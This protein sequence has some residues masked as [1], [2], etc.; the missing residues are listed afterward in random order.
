[1]LTLNILR[2]PVD[3]SW[4][5]LRIAEEAPPPSWKKVFQDAIPELRDISIL[6][7]EQEEAYGEYYPLKKDIFAAFEYTK[8]EDVKIVIF[9]QD[10]YHQTIFINGKPT[11]RPI[12]LS[13]SVRQDDVIPSSLKN[14]YIELSNTVRGFK[15]PD[16]GDLREWARQGVLLL[17]ACLTVKP[18]KAGSHGEIWLG[19]INKVLKAIAAVNPYCIYML[20][21]RDAQKLK[22]MLG[23]RSVILEAAHPSGFSANKGFFGCDHFNKANNHLV[24]QGKYAITWR[25]S[26]REELYSN[27]ITV[28]S[29]VVNIA[30]EPILIPVNPVVL[31]SIITKKQHNEIS[32]PLIV[33][34]TK[35]PKSPSLLSN[36]PL[37]PLIPRI[38][39]TDTTEVIKKDEIKL[40]DNSN[41]LDQT[42]M[43]TIPIIPIIPK[44]QYGETTKKNV[45]KDNLIAK[46]IENNTLS[47]LKITNQDATSLGLPIIP[48]LVK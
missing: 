7:N 47:N 27:T 30:P 48:A 15:T 46:I 1:M 12:G 41:N 25:I 16:H 44:I 8:L 13:F 6:L 2:E 33:T 39:L 3:Q 42:P 28:P 40:E 5:I 11:P 14:I 37:L 24:R 35:T 20:W 9:G 23:E 21:G 10:P 18:G 17:N 36:L 4:S 34:G 26:T 29:P 31:P 45:P 22:T 43:K 38:D 32:L 19:F